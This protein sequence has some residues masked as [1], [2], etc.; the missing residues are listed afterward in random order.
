M[1]EGPSGPSFGNS[2]C[3]RLVLSVTMMSMFS[4]RSWLRRL[5]AW[6]LSRC[7]G[8]ARE[9]LAY[10]PSTSNRLVELL[11][12]DSLPEV[13][14]AVARRDHLPHDLCMP[15]VH[16]DDLLVRMALASQPLDTSCRAVLL[17]DLELRVVNA[18]LRC[19]TITYQE[20]LDAILSSPRM[21]LS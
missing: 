19:P 11:A 14:L 4:P 3:G 2:A 12:R 15:L 1:N 8:A 10:R 17:R 13:R 5:S 16:D 21:L 20:R 9:V 18:M 6:Y 7:S